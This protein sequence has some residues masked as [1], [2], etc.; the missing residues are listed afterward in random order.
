MVISQKVI[1]RMS[2]NLVWHSFSTDPSCVANYKKIRRGHVNFMLIW[3]GMTHLSLIMSTVQLSAVMLC[4]DSCTLISSSFPDSTF[5]LLRKSLEL[6]LYA[7]NYNIVVH[8]FVCNVFPK[9]HTKVLF[10]WKIMHACMDIVGT[11]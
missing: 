7:A 2:P 8:V 5:G 10:A 9:C 11:V 3:Y 1:G 4:A 6:L